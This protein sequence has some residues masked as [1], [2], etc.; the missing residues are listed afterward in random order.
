MTLI[1][2]LDTVRYAI[3][4]LYNQV[5]NLL[6][7]PAFFRSIIFIRIPGLSVFGRGGSK[8]IRFI[9]WNLRPFTNTCDIYITRIGI[10]WNNIL[11][12]LI[13][14]GAWQN[15]FYVN[16]TYHS[17]T[18]NWKVFSTF[19]SF[20][21]LTIIFITW[22]PFV[23]WTCVNK[24]ITTKWATTLYPFWALFWKSAVFLFIMLVPT[25]YFRRRARKR[26]FN[27]FWK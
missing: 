15:I 14:L 20:Q 18:R 1:S 3:T 19:R 4:P 17:L 12:L 21:I 6:R 22:L 9:N 2:I 25:R 13:D 24:H 7:I 8:I 5:C 11:K 26:C 27:W 16:H 10:R 23:C